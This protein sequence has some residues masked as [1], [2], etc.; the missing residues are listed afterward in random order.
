MQYSQDMDTLVADNEIHTTIG[1]VPKQR[2]VRRFFQTRELP[3]ILD[4]A[5]EH[6]VEFVEELP[7]QTRPLVFVPH[8][9]SLDIKFRLRLDKKLPGHPSDQRWR[10]LRSM[11][12]R[13]SVHDRPMPGFAVYAA[14]RS[15][16]ISWC[17]SGSGT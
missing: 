1:K 16:M 3:G 15:R 12:E 14:K 6:V 7:S 13:T 2:T 10:N 11:S 4:N 17:H 9:G 8:S 5:M